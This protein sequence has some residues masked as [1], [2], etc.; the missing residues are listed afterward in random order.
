[1]KDTRWNQSI[2]PTSKKRR[3]SKI[4]VTREEKRIRAHQFRKERSGD[5]S[6]GDLS[7]KPM[8]EEKLPWMKK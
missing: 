8:D 2:A 3:H 5:L 4:A 7:T 1:M 6:K